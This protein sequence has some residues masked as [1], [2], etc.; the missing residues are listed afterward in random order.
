MY[1]PNS[2]YSTLGNSRNQF[3]QS[4]QQQYDFSGWGDRLTSIEEGIKGLTENFK[5][6]NIPGEE[7]G[8]QSSA[9]EAEYAGNTAPPPLAAAPPA[10]GIPSI[11]ITPGAIDTGAEMIANVDPLAPTT[12]TAQPESLTDVPATPTGGQQGIPYID[13]STAVENT[14]GTP[15]DVRGDWGMPIDWDMMPTLYGRGMGCKGQGN[16]F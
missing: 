8:E 1:N 3:S 10:G 9:P 5:N 14:R 12:P 4:Q 6:I 15:R 7:F 16:G 13:P 2:P 11:P